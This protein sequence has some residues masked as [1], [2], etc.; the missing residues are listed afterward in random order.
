MWI[1]EEGA[2]LTMR[3]TDDGR[4]KG[5]GLYDAN[6]LIGV[7]G[8]A[9][10]D[11]ST[12]CYAMSKTV[13]AY[14]P[15]KE[16]LSLMAEDHRL[17]HHFMLYVSHALVESYNDIELSTL[18]TLEDKI[19]AFEQRMASKRFPQ[20]TSLSEVV[21]AMAVGAHPVSVNRSKKRSRQSQT[22]P[23]NIQKPV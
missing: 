14:V 18:G 10:T 21:T 15:M 3:E 7:A 9:E 6:S 4:I 20:D 16:F 19:A 11:R 8:V 17:C 5:I 1:V 23:K 12:T 22:A 2:L 13:L